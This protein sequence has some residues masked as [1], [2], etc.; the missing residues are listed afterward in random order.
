MK[1]ASFI[2][3]ILFCPFTLLFGQEKESSIPFKDRLYFGG[4]FG[5]NF[6]RV[7]NA[8]NP[9][10]NV[11]YAEVSPRIGIRITEGFSAGP[12]LIY[13]YYNIDKNGFS[14]YG[15][16]IFAR[17]NI[18]QNLFLQSE[19][20]VLNFQPLRRNIFGEFIDRETVT[21]IFVGGGYSA[22]VSNFAAMNIMVLFNLNDSVNSPYSNPVIRIGFVTGI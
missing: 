10:Y 17:Q 9:A 20:E 14:N 15:A 4:N 1:K 8:P 13:Q 18:F 21:S 11:F 7:N 16:S 12:G 5:L 3:F 2:L 6:A 22:R 19:I